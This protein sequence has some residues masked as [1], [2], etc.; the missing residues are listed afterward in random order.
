MQINSQIQLLYSGLSDVFNDGG[1]SRKVQFQQ[2]G[3][4]WFWNGGSNY[5]EFIE[6][7]VYFKHE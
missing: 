2:L 3:M 7:I 1:Q 4:N 6:L 5:H